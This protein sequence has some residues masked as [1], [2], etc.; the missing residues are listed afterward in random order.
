MKP[1][2]CVNCVNANT[3]STF[4]IKKL[5]KIFKKTIQSPKTIEK[6]INPT[7]AQPV[8]SQIAVL[9]TTVR[10]VCQSINKYFFHDLHIRCKCSTRSS[11]APSS[12]SSLSLLSLSFLSLPPCVSICKRLNNKQ[13]SNQSIKTYSTDKLCNLK[14][15]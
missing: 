15:I 4:I 14:F 8:L 6:S 10:K 1:S 3:C 12:S 9:H 13:H 5:S 2:F 7:T 11:I